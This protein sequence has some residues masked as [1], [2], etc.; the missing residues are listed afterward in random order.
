LTWF[1]LH[2]NLTPPTLTLHKKGIV[3]AQRIHD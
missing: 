3:G 2:C 1:F